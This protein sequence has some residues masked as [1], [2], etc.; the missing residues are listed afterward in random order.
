MIPLQTILYPF[1]KVMSNFKL[2]NKYEGLVLTLVTFGIPIT[3]YQIAAYFKGIPSEL[4]DSAKMDGASLMR[5]IFQIMIP[6]S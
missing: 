3:T 1:Y 5:I 2:L 6:I 4:I